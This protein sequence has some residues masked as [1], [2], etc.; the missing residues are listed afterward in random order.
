MFRGR[1]WIGGNKIIVFEEQAAAIRGKK[2]DKRAQNQEYT[3]TKYILNRLIR[4]KRDSIQRHAIC[5]LFLLDLD[6]IRIA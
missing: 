2:D 6:T 4:M 3:N 1:Q 5:V